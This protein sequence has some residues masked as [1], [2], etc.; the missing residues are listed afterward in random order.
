MSSTKELRELTPKEIENILDF[1]KPNKSIPRDASNAI[2]KNMKQRFRSQLVGQKIYPAIIPQLKAL[3][4]KNYKESLIQAGE[5]VGIIAAQSIGEKNTQSSVDY[6]EFILIKQSDDVIKIKIGEFID[7]Y[8]EKFGRVKLTNG[9]E[10]QLC[11]DVYVLTISQ[12]EK[13]E[14]KEINEVSRHPP[15]GDLVK[16]TTESGRNI[17]T[18]FSHSHLK[19]HERNIIPV[20]GSELKVGDQ[21]PVIKNAPIPHCEKNNKDFDISEYIIGRV[22]PKEYD[23]DS[24]N[25]TNVNDYFFLN[26]QRIKRYIKNDELFAWFIGIFLIYGKYTDYGITIVCSD[27][28][29]EFQNNL[30]KFCSDYDIHKDDNFDHLFSIFGLKPYNYTY[31]LNSKILKTFLIKLCGYDYKKIPDFLFKSNKNIIKSFLCTYL[32]KN[33]FQKDQI[34]RL[35]DISFLLTYFGIYSCVDSEKLFIHPSSLT[36]FSAQFEFD[37]SIINIKNFTNNIYNT[38][39]ADFLKNIDRNS[40]RNVPLDELRY[41]EEI[42]NSDVV[43]EKIVK[44]ELV[45]ESNYLDKYG[46]Y[47]YD[48]SVDNNETFALLSG[49]V[50][51]NTLNTLIRV[52]Y[53][54]SIASLL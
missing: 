53:T 35:K 42:I 30:D 50:V 1:I 31:H 3:L 27:R 28:S 47:V 54:K 40:K 48:F 44:L 20:L 41:Y 16:L 33:K 39:D 6:N 11:K 38:S 8:L 21:I 29:I 26:K 37:V 36:T 43:W 5:S 32:S 17:I 34:D 46:K 12:K 22:G 18:T 52:S 15:H 9:S 13:I 19:K 14:W 49:I 51:H 24:D 4:E 2:V 25:E 7:E 10:I 23:T 45:T